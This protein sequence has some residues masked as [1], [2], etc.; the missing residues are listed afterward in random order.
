GWSIGRGRSCWISRARWHVPYTTRIWRLTPTSEPCAATTGAA[1]A[2]RRRSRRSRV[3]RTRASSPRGARSGALAWARRAA[4]C[5][6]SAGRRCPSSTGSTPATATTCPTRSGR[7]WCRPRWRSPEASV[8]T[9][10]PRDD[11]V[12]RAVASAAPVDDVELAA[13]V[14]AVHDGPA[15]V[16]TAR[17]RGG[18][19]EV[20]LL[21]EVLPDV[22]DVEVAG[23]AVEGVPPRI[24]QPLGEVLGCGGQRGDVEAQE[25]RQVAR[26]ALRVAHRIP[27]APAVAHADVEHAV[28]T[29]QVEAA[30]VVREGL[31]DGE[32][33]LLA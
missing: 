7:G 21:E 15:V 20:D 17:E 26:V 29:E 32:H 10:G 16:E 9:L 13:R 6:A 22:G 27:A 5:C 31:V 8:P 25:L 18:G 4:S 1:C 11:L 3:A 2:S 33:Q 14:E 24:A 23:G 19:H 28:G 30:V 12:D